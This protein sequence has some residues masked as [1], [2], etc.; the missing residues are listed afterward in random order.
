[1]DSFKFSKIGLSGCSI[2]EAAVN[3]IRHLYNLVK[4]FLSAPQFVWAMVG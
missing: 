3:H 4:I 2:Y 1:M